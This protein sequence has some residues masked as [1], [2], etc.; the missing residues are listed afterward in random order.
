MR[1]AQVAKQHPQQKKNTAT[2]IRCRSG[3]FKIIMDKYR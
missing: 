1:D 2:A 3:V